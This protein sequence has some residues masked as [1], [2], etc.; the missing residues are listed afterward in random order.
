[1]ATLALQEGQAPNKKK[2]S[3]P[4]RSA[5][6]IACT[7]HS[8]DAKRVREAAAHQLYDGR[9]RRTPPRQLFEMIYLS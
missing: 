7:A 8:G 9:P 5:A 3:D 2:N 4:M 1:M 6:M